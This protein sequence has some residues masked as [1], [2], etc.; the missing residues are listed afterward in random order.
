MQRSWRDRAG[1]VVAVTLTWC[2]TSVVTHAQQ[3]PPSAR[4]EQPLP[5][6][7]MP[8]V[9]PDTPIPYAAIRSPYRDRVF[10]IMEKPIT[11][12]TS[13]AYVQPCHPQLFDW[14]C[15]HPEW[16]AEFWQ[17]MNIDVGAV[18]RTADGYA[19]QEG[20]HTRVDFH[21]VHEQPEMRIVYARGETKKPPMVTKMRGEM[22]IVHRYRYVPTVDGG[23]LLVQQ[24][25]GFAYAPGPVVRAMG[26][27]TKANT[28]ELVDAMLK[29][30]M[31]FF[32]VAQRVVHVRPEWASQVITRV[33]PRHPPTENAELMQI[34]QTMPID[35]SRRVAQAPPGATQ[36]TSAKPR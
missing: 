1:F 5:Q 25:E 10:Q 9:V 6:T 15:H 34:V 32:S 29:D 3:T 31:V 18:G 8:L 13:Q 16:A 26:K 36:S 17:A 20:D 30:M 7:T 35:P 28:T 27:V 23:H 33:A 11:H 24:I 22:V 21:V 4:A 14:L 12:R 19:V 2:G